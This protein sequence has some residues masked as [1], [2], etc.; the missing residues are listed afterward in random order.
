M[1]LPKLFKRH[2]NEINIDSIG[3]NLLS[4]LLKGE[5]IDRDMAMSLP[6]VTKA[7]SFICDTISTIPIYLYKEIDGKVN[8]VKGDNRVFLLNDDTKDTLD[9]V[10]FKRA[11]VEDYLL[12]KGGYAYINK[13]RNVVKSLNYTEEKYITILKITIT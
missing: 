4:A 1:K 7:V 8:E 5:S 12:G 11:L 3:D 10:Q 9:G 13:T 6:A 2:K